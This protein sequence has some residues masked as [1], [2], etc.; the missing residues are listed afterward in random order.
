MLDDVTLSFSLRKE[1]I[2]EQQARVGPAKPFTAMAALADAHR[3]MDRNHFF[4]RFELDHVN[5]DTIVL[6]I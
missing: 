6:I 1:A 2:F 3:A 5:R 4:A